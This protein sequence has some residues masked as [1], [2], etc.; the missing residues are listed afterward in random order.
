MSTHLSLVLCVAK[1]RADK[2]QLNNEIDK[3]QTLRSKKIYITKKPEQ[4]M[5][6]S[7]SMPATH[8]YTVA[9]KRFNRL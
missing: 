3:R 4:V 1:D 6:P 7:C 8:I 9:E 5:P 2:T